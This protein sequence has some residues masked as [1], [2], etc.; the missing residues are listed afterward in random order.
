MTF[1]HLLPKQKKEV[2]THPAKY[3]VTHSKLYYN[4][5]L[6]EVNCEIFA[7]KEIGLLLVGMQ[8]MGKVDGSELPNSGKEPS[9]SNIFASGSILLFK[10]RSM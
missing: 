10:S 6:E 8:N 5:R 2:K 1:V 7:L 9:I 4:E 3:N